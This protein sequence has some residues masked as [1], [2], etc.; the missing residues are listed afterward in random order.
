[1]EWID[2]VLMPLLSLLVIVVFIIDIIILLPL[3]II[4]KTRKISGIGII[5]SSYVFGAFTWMCSF[6]IAYIIWGIAGLVIGLLLCGIGVVPIAMLATLF[7]GDWSTLL[8]VII[9]TAITIGSRYLGIYFR[10]KE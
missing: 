6:I 10:Y 4:K 2:T 9:I 3:A 8:Q 7:D 5:I 1:M